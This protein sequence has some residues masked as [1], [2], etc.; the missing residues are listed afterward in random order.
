MKPT[1]VSLSYS[2]GQAARRLSWRQPWLIFE[3]QGDNMTVK[4]MDNIGIVVEDIDAAIDF[5]DVRFCVETLD[6]L[7]CQNLGFYSSDFND[8]PRSFI[9]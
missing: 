1:L 9:A 2:P 4:R 3:L 6:S 5:G 7:A 8:P